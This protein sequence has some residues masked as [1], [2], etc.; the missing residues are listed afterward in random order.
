MSF[1]ISLILLSVLGIWVAYHLF[2]LRTGNTRVAGTYR[3]HPVLYWIII[4]A[5]ILFLIACLY[6]LFKEIFPYKK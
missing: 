5:Q 3:E 1:I 4:A 2:V 6:K